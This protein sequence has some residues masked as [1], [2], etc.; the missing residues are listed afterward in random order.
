MNTPRLV[1]ALACALTATTAPPHG[2]SYPRRWL[3]GQ[4]WVLG[5]NLE[6][7]GDRS[8]VRLQVVADP[9][10]QQTQGVRRSRRAPFVSQLSDLSR[11]LS[12]ATIS[13]PALT[14]LR[15]VSSAVLRL[16][17]PAQDQG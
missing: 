2:V 3:G 15:M 10:N 1:A 12:L 6:A 17:Q 13:R 11:N 14:L 5:L 8:M 4:V 7:E 16:S 9:R